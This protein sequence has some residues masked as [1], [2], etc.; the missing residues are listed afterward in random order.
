RVF[1]GIQINCAQCHDHPFDKWKREQFHELAAYFVRARSRPLPDSGSP[2]LVGIQIVSARFGEQRMARKDNP[3]SADVVHPRF[4]DGRAA[5]RP[6]SAGRRGRRLA[7][8]VT[9]KTTPWFAAASVTRTWGELMG[10]SF[11]QPVDD[12]GPQ[13]EAVFGAVLVRLAGAFRGSDYDVK[14]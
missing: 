12:M 5:G 13:R 6:R 8:A 2:R 10:Q 3:R 7:D 1:L 9:D 4:L 11:Y 14:A